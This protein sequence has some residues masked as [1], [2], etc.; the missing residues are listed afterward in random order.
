MLKV[1]GA[2]WLQ[3][4]ISSYVLG[5]LGVLAIIA[6]FAGQIERSQED[7]NYA[8]TV[9]YSEK[10]GYRIEYWG[11]SNKLAELPRGV[12]R[13][14]F[15][16]DMK[17]TGT[18][19]RLCSNTAP[20]QHR[21][22]LRRLLTVHAVTASRHPAVHAATASRRPAIHPPT[23][24]AW[25]LDTDRLS[26]DSADGAATAPTARRLL[27]VSA[28]TPH[29][30]LIYDVRP[31]RRQLPSSLTAVSSLTASCLLIYD[32]NVKYI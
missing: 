32:A 3:T 24:L 25:T 9:F 5:F 7:G 2:S 29:R 16:M 13:A 15:R 19:K 8:A 22:K 14:Y 4:K 26:G 18:L 21:P 6:L 23:A 20:T 27:A 10:T 30:P 1:V 31:A 17:T 28:R 12:A 11:Q